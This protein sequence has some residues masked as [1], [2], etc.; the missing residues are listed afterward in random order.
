MPHVEVGNRQH[1]IGVDLNKPLVNP[2][3]ADMGPDDRKKGRRKAFKKK[4]GNRK[5]GGHGSVSPNGQ[6]RPKKRSRTDDDPFDIDRFIGIVSN[7][8]NSEGQ[9]NVGDSLIRM[10]W[11]LM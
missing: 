11:T 8:T 10:V 3:E 5:T 6:D 1:V 9:E 2:I 4:R 7:G